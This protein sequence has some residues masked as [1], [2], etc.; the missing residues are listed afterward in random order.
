MTAIPVDQLQG[1]YT[2]LITPMK[3]GK[4][5]SKKV[6]YDK[7]EILIEDQIEA[8]VTGL[9]ACGTTG[10]S[11]T[12]TPSEQVKVIEFVYGH[13]ADVDDKVQFIAGAGSN[14]TAEAVRLSRR[15]EN[16]L[17]DSVTFLHVTPYY[18][19]PTQEGM[20][21]HFEAI[22]DKIDE[23][24]NLI[25]YNV[26][27]RTG[28]NLDNHTVLELA[29]YPN[30]IGIKEAG[31][32]V[33]R[34]KAVEVE[35]ELNPDLQFRVLSGDDY[36][37]AAA[38]KEGAFGVISATANVAPKYFA[39]LCNAALLDKHRLAARYQSGVKIFV[40]AT[41]SRTNPIPLAEM[42]GT[43]VRLPLVR[44]DRDDLPEDIQE[45]IGNR[46]ADLFGINL[47]KYQ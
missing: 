21:R 1:V 15:I 45:I 42:L 35:R 39:H 47:R 6:D 27:S 38:M 41:F 30:I 16:R 11:A 2:A 31:D 20:Q 22:A 7:L 33:A 32:V 34:T 25:L 3:E 29:D 19:R 18:N 4:G 9:V 37:V 14:S 5:L 24:S 8:G 17:G 46:D 13:I 26:P 44:K 10:Q 43:E 12:L 36:D 23:T 28:S 40:D